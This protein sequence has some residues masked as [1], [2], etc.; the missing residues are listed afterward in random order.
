MEGVAE[1]YIDVILETGE[2]LERVQ[3][4]WNPFMLY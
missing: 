2:F 1:V 3:H 4:V